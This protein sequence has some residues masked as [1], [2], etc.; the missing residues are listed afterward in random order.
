MVED[1]ERLR[2]EIWAAEG[3]LWP[4]YT[5][6]EPERASERSRMEPRATGEWRGVNQ[7]V[8]GATTSTMTRV[9][10]HIDTRMTRDSVKVNVLGRWSIIPSTINYS[11]L[12]EARQ[13]PCH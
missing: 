12:S 4:L 5:D 1:V 8:E 6:P 2:T 9:R 10:D 11:H 7:A 13:C 3:G